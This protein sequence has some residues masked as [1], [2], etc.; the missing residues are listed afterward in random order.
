M[1]PSS[2]R[3]RAISAFSLLAG[4]STRACLAVTALRMRESMSE[5]GS[6]IS[7]SLSYK[8]QIPGSKSQTP[9]NSQI[10]GIWRLGCG[11]WDLPAALGH[12]GDVALEREL[13]EAKAAHRE[14]PDVGAR[15]SA[16]PAAVAQPDLVLRRLG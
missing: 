14:L 4:R 16:Q 12:P 1:Y 15:P 2:W 9:S 7:V 3:I 13:A 10:S 5:I 11:F 6:V 8:S